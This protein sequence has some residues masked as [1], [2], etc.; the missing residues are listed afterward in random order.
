MYIYLKDALSAAY[1]SAKC[2]FI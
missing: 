2:K 1:F